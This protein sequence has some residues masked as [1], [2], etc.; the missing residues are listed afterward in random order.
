MWILIC[1]AGI[2]VLIALIFWRRGRFRRKLYATPIPEAWREILQGNVP[3]YRRLPADLRRQLEGHIQVFV[4]EKLFEGGE[5]LEVTDEMRV[6]IA[7]HACLLLLNRKTDYYPRLGSIIIYPR[8]YESRQI[9]QDGLLV[10]EETS[11][12][13]GEASDHGTV[14]LSWQDVI[15]EARADRS[16]YNVA[17]HEF[18]HHLD[19]EDGFAD[20][21]PAIETVRQSR[22]WSQVFAEEYRKLRERVEKRQRSVI[23]EYGASEPAEFFAVATETFFEKGRKLR[24][25]HPELYEQLR[26]LY[27]VDP[28]EWTE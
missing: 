12:K 13:L 19:F 9:W 22:Q 23:D 14:S 27:Q 7:G 1:L 6:T 4:A 25:Q 20:G 18:A 17:L 11:P 5:G 3:L 26:V 24:T 15:R 21:M 16:G 8:A 2:L 10:V 28:A